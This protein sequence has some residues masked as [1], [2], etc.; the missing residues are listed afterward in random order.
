MSKRTQKR[1]LNTNSK[2]WQTKSLVAGWCEI[3]S[4]NSKLEYRCNY[5]GSWKDFFP[6]RNGSARVRRMAKIVN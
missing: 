4:G 1:E 5:R 6:A 2:G 3:S